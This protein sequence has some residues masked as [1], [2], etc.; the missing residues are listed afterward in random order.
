MTQQEFTDRTG[1]KVTEEEYKDIEA[2]YYAVPNMGKD[3]F[4]L[5]YKRVGS[6]ALTVQMAARIQ[7]LTGMLEKAEGEMKK[8]EDEMKKMEG[9]MKKMEDEMRCQ[10]DRMVDLAGVL[11]G[12][13]QV[14]DDTDFEKEAVRLVGERTVIMMKLWTGYPLREEEKEYVG[15][16]LN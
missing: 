16:N 14:Y 11:I 10:K 6:N 1:L 3:A 2:M 12:K 8:K 15:E 7:S 13:A 4:C 9:E 5:C